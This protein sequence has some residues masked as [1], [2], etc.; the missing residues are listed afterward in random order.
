MRAARTDVH[1]CLLVRGTLGGNARAVRAPRC[2][3]TLFFAAPRAGRAMLSKLQAA[4]LARSYARL[5]PDAKNESNASWGDRA[6]GLPTR[7]AACQLRFKPRILWPVQ[8]SAQAVLA[9]GLVRR[10]WV[11]PEHTGMPAAHGPLALR[12]MWTPSQEVYI[13]LGA[14]NHIREWHT[15]SS[16]VQF[17]VAVDGK[18]V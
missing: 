5:N 15:A 17:R 3:E 10:R 12:T 16:A 2:H 1:V 7:S 14:M 11:G 4:T 6:R 13:Q 8:G 9:H 18:N